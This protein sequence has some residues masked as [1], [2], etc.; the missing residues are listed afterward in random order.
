M[1]KRNSGF[2]DKSPKLP[3]EIKKEKIFSSIIKYI[4]HNIK[5]KIKAAVITHPD[6][7]HFGWINDILK[8]EKIDFHQRVQVMILIQNWMHQIM[9]V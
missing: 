8:K 2:F 3:S 7:D 9:N 6:K 5:N 4:K 1:E